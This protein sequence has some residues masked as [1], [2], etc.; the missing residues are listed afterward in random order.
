MAGMVILFLVNKLIVYSFRCC[1]LISYII[2]TNSY[3]TITSPVWRISRRKASFPR[4]MS[5]VASTPTRNQAW[6]TFLKNHAQHIWACD[7][8]TVYDLLFRPVFT[9][10]IIELHTRRILHTVVTYAPTDQWVTQQLRE[11]ASWGK[12]PKSPIRD[13]DKKYGPLFSSLLKAI[14]TPKRSPRA[15]AICERFNGSLKREC[16]DYM[17][18]SCIASSCIAWCRNTLRITTRLDLIR[19]SSNRPPIGMSRIIR[20]PWALSLLR[21][22]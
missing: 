5:K 20:S 2:L 10:F 17:L 12:R 21:L 16:L 19:V 1:F 18:S 7:Y 6:K 8:T 13:R 15:N 14:K 9:F 3:R 22:C 4:R 11:G